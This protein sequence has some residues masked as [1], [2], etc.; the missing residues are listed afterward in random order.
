[1]FPEETLAAS[2]AVGD[3]LRE[4]GETVAVAESCTGG[5]VGAA[6]T[7]VPGAS[8]YF[9]RSFGTYAYDAKLE[10]LG[11]DRETLDERGAVC[12]PVATQMARGARDVAGT[13]WGVATTGIAGPS[14]GTEEKPVGTVWLAVAHAGEW[15]TQDSYAVAER[16]VLDGDRAGVRSATVD[17]ALAALSEELAH[18][19]G[20]ENV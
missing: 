14:G 11:V 1:M 7:A 12:E 10:T 2:R 20:G 17:R 3:R 4:R 13:D 15:G 18:G 19:D 5:L 6:L 16:H 8:D 9:D